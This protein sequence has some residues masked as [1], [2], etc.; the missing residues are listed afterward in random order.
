MESPVPEHL[1]TR[2]LVRRHEAL[3]VRANEVNVFADAVLRFGIVGR[4]IRARFA[5]QLE[6]E[7]RHAVVERLAFGV[8]LEH[9]SGEDAAPLALRVEHRDPPVVRGQA[10]GKHQYARSR[11][12]E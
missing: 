11:T 12:E 9:R 8:I 5:E 4:E 3:Q 10:L 6:L 2:D 7:V 1:W